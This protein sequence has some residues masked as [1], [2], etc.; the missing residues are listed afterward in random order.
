MI[1]THGTND[2][3]RPTVTFTAEEIA[4]LDKPFF[5]AAFELAATMDQPQVAYLH[6]C[7]AEIHGMLMQL[8]DACAGLHKNPRATELALIRIAA[9]AARNARMAAHIAQQ[10]EKTRPRI[11]W[12]DPYNGPAW[13][14]FQAQGGRAG[15]DALVTA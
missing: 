10:P 9:T 12:G 2:A 8:R 14:R 1:G 15:R 3:G 4:T 6:R 5:R 11:G 13:D 7:D